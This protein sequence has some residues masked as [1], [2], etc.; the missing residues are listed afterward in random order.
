MS[1][2]LDFTF[3]NAITVNRPYRRTSRVFPRLVLVIAVLVGLVVFSQIRW[4]PAGMLLSR[5]TPAEVNP[6][7]DDH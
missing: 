3:T 4:D 7:Y 2:K 1:D 6:L 5:L